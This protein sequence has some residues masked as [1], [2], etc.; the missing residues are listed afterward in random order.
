LPWSHWS[1]PHGP[2]ERVQKITENL[3]RKAL[4]ESATSAVIVVGIDAAGKVT[5][6]GEELAPKD[7][8]ARLDE[9]KQK[10]AGTGVKEIVI[11]IRAAAR[12]PNVRVVQLINDLQNAGYNKVRFR[13]PK[14]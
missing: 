2:D 3:L 4:G 7:M 13:V 10:A 8:K 11:E 9:L 5:I 12:T 1:R 14:E 6:E